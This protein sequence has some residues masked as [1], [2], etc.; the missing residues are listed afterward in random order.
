MGAWGTGPFDNDDAADFATSLDH[1][2]PELRIGAIRDA[3]TDAAEQ[4]GYLDRDVGGAA[5][6]AAALVAA[7]GDKGLPIDCIHGPKQLIPEAP[8][9]AYGGPAHRG[10]EHRPGPAGLLIEAPA[11]ELQQTQLV[12]ING[13]RRPRAGGQAAGGPDRSQIGIAHLLVA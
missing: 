4:T 12:L 3:L 11:H 2:Q 1:L 6:A 7:Q 10:V 8:V 5:V 9:V 13:S